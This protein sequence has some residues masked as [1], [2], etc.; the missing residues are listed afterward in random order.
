MAL[1]VVEVNLADV[2]ETAMSLMQKKA[3]DSD[4]TLRLEPSNDVGVIYADERRLKQ[5]LFN[6][7]SNAIHFTGKSGNVTL[8]ASRH[9]R[10][11]AIWVQDTGSGI[12]PKHQPAVFDRFE[13]TGGK[14]KRGAGLGLSLVKSFV[15]LHG[16]WVSLESEVGKGTKV[17]CHIADRVQQDAAE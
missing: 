17:T 8:G 14:G 2:L 4:L 7:L 5:I 6:L 9:G 12:D 13:N 3:L 10:D 11:V 16:G 15:E 1:E